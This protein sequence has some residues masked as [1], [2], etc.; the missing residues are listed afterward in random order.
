MSDDK[1]DPKTDDSS[2]RRFLKS[3]VKGGSIAALIGSGALDAHLRLLLA[4][5]RRTRLS[6]EALTGKLPSASLETIRDLLKG[7]YYRGGRFFKGGKGWIPADPA[8]A[9]H[10]DQSAC[11]E[12]W[13]LPGDCPSDTCGNN[14]CDRQAC[15]DG[16]WCGRNTCREQVCG[17]VN[18]RCG[19]WY[20]TATEVDTRKLPGFDMGDIGKYAGGG[21]GGEGGG[22]GGGGHT[23][24][25]T[26][27]EEMMEI[28]GLEV[29]ALETE[30]REM[31]SRGLTFRDKGYVR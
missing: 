11:T 2:R 20:L 14:Y 28:R 18:D 13:N 31:I 21:A 12:E 8:C 6:S 24:P 9:P 25:S 30:I 17:G 1:R 16:Y 4:E 7:E 5:E 3:A 23:S 29:R 22:G 27:L 15:P 26:F 10:S 19:E